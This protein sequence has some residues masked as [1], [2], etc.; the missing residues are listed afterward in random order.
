MALIA[1]SGVTFSQCSAPSS[2]AARGATGARKSLRAN[3]GIRA[4][5]R[6]GLAIRCA[7]YQ[8]STRKVGPAGQVAFLSYMCGVDAVC[9]GYAQSVPT[10]W[11]E[12]KLAHSEHRRRLV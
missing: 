2:L 5:V 6:R 12:K 9:F 11:L 1:A 8:W 10:R 4:P 3:T 7:A